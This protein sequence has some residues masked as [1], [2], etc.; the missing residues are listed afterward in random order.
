[1][2][3]FDA[4]YINNSGGKVLLDYL[5]S[6]LNKSTHNVFYLLDNRCN[7]SYPFLPA[8]KTLYLEAS[9]LNRHKFYKKNKQRFSKILCFANIPPTV[10]LNI[11][12]YTYFHNLLLIQQPPS[13]PFKNKI[14]AR[15]KGMLIKALKNY[16]DYFIVQ[17]G[18][19]KDELCSSIKLS[20][21]KC[22]V[23][24]FYR[25][26]HIDQK[27]AEKR[28]EFV[29]ISNG[30]PHKNHS[31]LIKAWQILKDQKNIDLPL[32]L[33][34]TD[35]YP[36]LI[37]Q[38]QNLNSEGYKIYNHKE[39]DVKQLFRIC[40]YSIYPSLIESF[41][42]GLIESIDT[43]TELIAADL[44]YVDAVVKPLEKFNPNNAQSIADAV[45]RAI[46]NSSNKLISQKK[47]A[48]Q[49]AELISLLS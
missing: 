36:A 35:S 10:K 18:N 49:I 12:V 14:K 45:C 47:V 4:L 11:P 44:P 39:V 20:K 34:I 23:I 19:V 46:Q 16:T 38:I 27:F 8:E 7:G 24:P 29:Y 21:E 42:L 5:I 6:E 30:N 32:H 15:M 28:N 37:E 48:D 43:E 13:Y 1:M 41:G 33:T 40:K 17:S 26:V 9:L 22:L 25:T 31:A 3:L 2:L